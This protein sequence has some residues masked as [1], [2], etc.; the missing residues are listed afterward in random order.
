[1]LYEDKYIRID[2]E[3]I[4]MTWYYFP[5][6]TAKRIRF[7]DMVRFETAA[8]LA[9]PWYAYKEWGMGL[10]SIWWA[11][12][13]R[14]QLLSTVPGD[15]LVVTIRGSRIRAGCTM[16]DR[17]RV[18]A[19]LRERAPHAASPLWRPKKKKKKSNTHCESS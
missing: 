13:R 11:C 19:I 15:Q 3:G 8:D 16:A 14:S 5:L 18:L 1:V 17:A 12:G 2:T 6:F 4:R 10:S 9:L 7:A